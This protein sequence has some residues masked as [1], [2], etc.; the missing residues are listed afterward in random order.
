MGDSP[1]V[2]E[3]LA[4]GV[5][6]HRSAVAIVS[7]LVFVLSLALG[8]PPKIDSNLLHLLPDSD[9]IV[10]AIR[11]IDEE[12]GGLNILSLS[13]EG[14]D[15]EALEAYLDTLEQRFEAMDD[16][17]FAIHELDEELALHVGMLQFS[18]GEVSEL[19]V[20]LQGALALGSALN[21]M[22]LQALMDMGPLTERIANANEIALF[23][24]QEGQGKLIVRPS[25]SASDP[26]FA[27]DFMRGVDALLEELPP[28]EAG[29]ALVWM[30]GAYRHTVEDVQG[31]QRD[32]VMTSVGS[33]VLVLSVIML[34]FRSWRAVMLV[35]PPLLLANAVLFAVAKVG[36]GALNTY[37]S[38]GSAILFGLGI[39][40]AIHLVGRYREIASAGVDKTDAIARAWALTGPPCA[41]AA[42]TSAAG[43]LA[44]S[45]AEFKGFAQL[46]VLLAVGLIVC[47]VAMLVLLPL[48]IMAFDRE[49]KLLLGA[50]DTDAM[51]P[52][53]SSYRFAPVGLIGALIATLVLGFFAVPSLEYE[54][55]M[56]AMRR[57][58]MSYAEL[59]EEERALARESYSPVA[60]TFD[61]Y[62]RMVA[63]QEQIDASVKA[64][65]M[66]HVG[67]TVSI[68]KVLPPDQDARNV[69]I[70]KL[71]KLVEHKNL[72]YLPPDFARRLLPLRGLSVQRL[73]REDLPAGVLQLLGA[74][75]PDRARLLMTPRGNMWDVREARAL[76][77]EVL[78]AVDDDVDVASEHIG[79]SRMFILALKDAPLVA[80][81]AL[82][83]VTLL[84]FWDLRRPLWTVGAVLTLV[85][86]MIWAAGAL[87]VGGIKLSLIN[88]TGIPILMGIG[89]DV[90]IHLL[91]RLREEGPG[92]VRRSLR[93][94]GVAAG[95]STLTT[96]C[97]FFSLTLAGN[98]GVRSLGV[99]VVVG[100]VVVF[101]VSASMLPLSWSAG[102]RVT[103]RAP[104]DNPPLPD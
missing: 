21:P 35:F 17:D 24:D 44:L 2:Y 40:F 57:D 69:Q 99:L 89:V 13:F 92:G 16:V 4:R 77:V 33:L 56:S 48:L 32:L 26:I 100:L 64:G 60:V 54:Y 15:P 65:E 1:G 104:A 85:A 84:A 73:E 52:S 22:V 79:V 3:R 86:G 42:L 41:T 87:W 5:M 95:L 20:R 39:D 38:F 19:N 37:T 27:R 46:G 103:G 58:G 59:S 45:A 43:F 66:P 70:T 98:R 50:I 63:A 81:L 11:K 74:T 102:W 101:I 8:L 67:G 68:A 97:S 6:E 62:E 51:M 7:T 88:L 90:I 36:F 80:G 72:R 94:T 30:G 47:L 34:S 29:L 55:D 53:T 93:T 75:R 14:D 23:G 18:P 91:H 9:R 61:S 25:R 10:S 78:G 83:F 76:S 71:V 49:P 82:F 31:I 12:E 96:I 28:E